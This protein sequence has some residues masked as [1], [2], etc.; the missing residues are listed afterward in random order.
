MTE[1]LAKR[2]SSAVESS[3]IIGPEHQGFHKG[4]R[5]KGNFFIVNLLLACTNNKKVVGHLLFLDLKEAYDQVE[6][7]T[8]YPKLGQLNFPE[9]FVIF[10]QD[11]YSNDFVSMDSAW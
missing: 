9:R 10:L 3:R 8:L 6:R 11:Y 4:R 7:P 2:I 1:I 5:C